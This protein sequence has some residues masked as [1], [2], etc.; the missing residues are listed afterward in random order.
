MNRVMQESHDEHEA[1]SG[2]ARASDGG[3]GAHQR[4][5]RGHPVAGQRGDV[6]QRLHEVGLADPV[7]PGQH[8]DP[9]G[10]VDLHPRIGPEVDQL[11]TPYVH[12]TS[13]LTTL[14]GRPGG[15][16]AELAAQRRHHFRRR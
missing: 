1:A 8:A 13:A 15:V 12:A 11:Q 3:A 6:A 10:E 5:V 7:R 16:A 14:P 9:G 4:G 2:E